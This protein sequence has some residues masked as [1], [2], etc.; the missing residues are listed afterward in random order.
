MWR[1]KRLLDPDDVLAPGVVLNHEPNAHL[2]GLKTIPTIEAVADACIECGFCESVCPSRDLTTTPRQRIVLRREM[3]RQP[4]D[5]AVTD[6]LLESYGY[7]AIDTCAGDSTCMIA[8]PV[9]IDTGAMMRVSATYGTP[10]RGAQRCP[11]REGVAAAER[12]IRAA[13]GVADHLSDRV[14]EDVTSAVRE[15]V[16]PELIPDGLPRYPAREPT[17]ASD[18]S[19]HRSRRLLRGM[20]QPD[21]RRPRQRR[22]AEGHRRSVTPC[23]TA[24]VDP[25]RRRGFLLRDHLAL[26]GLRR[27]QCGDGQ[28]DR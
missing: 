17:D 9:G 10:P 13:L 23:W 24:G 1:I 6:A 2:Q 5:S 22:L 15:V 4:A 19:G 3:L 28:S 21:L 8:C 27:G 14:L 12:S 16:S 25:D 11:D 7:D 20:C 18:R 26:Q